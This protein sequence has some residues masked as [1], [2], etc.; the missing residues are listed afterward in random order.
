MNIKIITATIFSALLLTISYQAQQSKVPSDIEISAL[1]IETNSH[2]PADNANLQRTWSDDVQIMIK[3]LSESYRNKI[4]LIHIQAKL[5]S[6][7]ESIINHLPQPIDKNLKSVLAAT[8]PNQHNSILAVWSKM[9]QYEEWLIEQNRT[10]MELDDLNRSGFLWQ[11]RHE[12]F[13]TAAEDIW[14]E[15]HDLYETAQLNF[16]REVELLDQSFDV[17]MHKR[18]ERLQTSFQQ[19]D[20]VF[21]RS[22][23]AESSSHK[24]TVAS[25]LFGLNSVQKELQQ[26]DPD[27]RKLEI[28]SIRRELGFDEESIIKM[29]DLDNKREQ[30]WR[31]G[32]AYMTSRNQLLANNENI[33]SSELD[34]LR[35]RFFGSSAATIAREEMSGFYRFE[36]KRYYGRN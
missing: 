26:L 32:Y 27:R 36:R 23:G 4:H 17:P 8:F 30:R 29:S 2:Y 5:I 33:P 35:T 13:P 19:A 1:A 22:I 7:R 28:E 34:A 9:D 31:N 18:I 24:N 15:E 25:V 3:Q 10:L 14:T 12:L 11:K 21:T 20:N 16:H 6:I